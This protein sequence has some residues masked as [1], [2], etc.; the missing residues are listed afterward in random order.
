MKSRFETSSRRHQIGDEMAD[1]L[2]VL[3]P[4]LGERRIRKLRDH[5]LQHAGSTSG[6]LQ[7]RQMIRVAASM[8]FASGRTPARAPM[9]AIFEDRRR[10]AR[11]VAIAFRRF[12]DACSRRKSRNKG[13]IDRSAVARCAAR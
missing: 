11:R 5:I 2:P 4:G 8:S 9:I 10:C 13:G 1:A 7:L 3:Q 6:L 12:R